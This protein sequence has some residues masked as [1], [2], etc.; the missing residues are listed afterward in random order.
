MPLSSTT[1]KTDSEED[2]E[3]PDCKSLQVAI[4][5]FDIH[6]A[7]ES[8]ERQVEKWTEDVNKCT[9]KALQFKK[10][11]QNSLALIQL[12]RRKQIQQHIDLSSQE[13][14]KLMQIR[15]T[16]ESTKSNKMM[17]DLMVESTKML[18]GLREETPL[19][20]VDEVNDDLQSELH[21]HHQINES[22]A[23]SSNIVMS[24]MGIDT[25]DD[26]DL[27]KELQM[28]SMEDFNMSKDTTNE[29][30]EVTKTEVQVQVASMKKVEGIVVEKVQE[31]KSTEDELIE[32]MKK[33]EVAS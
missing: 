14:T 18:R 12:K 10:Q 7:E 25:I 15:M 16:I 31:E 23:M 4:T 2:T 6:K 11:N 24:T 3:L 21:E 26:D 13:L 9:A 17:V 33:L 32:T 5:L 30:E 1:T 29:K 28:L 20:H 8:I 22:F 19:E 27:T